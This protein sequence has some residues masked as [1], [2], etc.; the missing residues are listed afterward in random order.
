MPAA[1]AKTLL[2]REYPTIDVV[3]SFNTAVR[4]E[5][6]AV[7][8]SDEVGTLQQPRS[9]NVA[10]VLAAS[11]TVWRCL[12]TLC[13]PVARLRAQRPTSVL[14]GRFSAPTTGDGVLSGGQLWPFQGRGAPASSQQYLVVIKGVN[15]ELVPLMVNT[16]LS[17][18]SIA[19][20]APLEYVAVALDEQ[21]FS[22]MRTLRVPAWFPT[23][24]V[25][26]VRAKH[27]NYSVFGTAAFNAL[28]KRTTA[29]IL[30]LLQRTGRH[31]ITTDVDLVWL[32][33]PLPWISAHATHDLQIGG[34]LRYPPSTTL[35]QELNTGF[36]SIRSTSATRRFWSRMVYECSDWTHSDDQFCLNALLLG[37]NASATLRMPKAGAI[38]TNTTLSQC[39]EAARVCPADARLPF[40]FLPVAYFPVTL[41]LWKR[42]RIGDPR[43][44]ARALLFHAACELG[45][46]NKVAAM[47]REGVIHLN[48]LHDAFAHADS[49]VPLAHAIVRRAEQ[50]GHRHSTSAML[51]RVAQ[52]DSLP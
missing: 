25:G 18:D 51:A 28:L 44:R 32:R 13:L 2:E 3:A 41:C 6:K 36:M 4:E 23:H 46:R 29:C 5:P 11:T 39:D 1:V 42:W 50:L 17:L 14:G 7:M 52:N 21:A 35:R 27:C 37:P 22:A 31:L 15:F 20:S 43:R 12:T 24:I 47:S 40:V 45:V 48:A 9:A 8:A 49:L 10:A 38:P 26:S 16:L 34:E 33:D 30:E 19:F